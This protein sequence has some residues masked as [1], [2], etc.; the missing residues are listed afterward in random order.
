[1][2]DADAP[3]FKDIS[4][5]I[6]SEP[7]SI[8]KLRKKIVLLDF[9][10][11]SCVNCIRT[12]PTLKELHK[13]YS[14]KDLVIIG[15]HTPEFEFEKNF[16][17]VKKIVEKYGLEYPIA[18]DLQNTTWK[19]YGNSYWPKVV[20]VGARGK[21]KMEH[22]GESG[23]DKIEEKVIEL[24]AENGA[25][26]DKEV[27]IEREKFDRQKMFE[28]AKKITPEIYFG[29]ERSRGFGNSQVCVSGSCIRFIDRGDHQQNLVYLN[30][31]W[32]QEKEFI[33]HPTSEEAH[34]SLKYTAKNVNA[35]LSQFF[36][37]QY[38]VYVLLDG[39]YLDRSV[40]GRDIKLDK[41]GKSFVL[42][43]SSDMYELVETETMQTHEIK[44]VSDSNEFAIYT[45]TFG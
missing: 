42:V 1:M 38:K 18:L 37:K 40:A 39:K 15:V 33:R 4:G 35:V 6:N 25:K 8:F 27:F 23:Y 36:G 44:L 12:L 19:L 14:D 32:E 13:K 9:W 34:V 3:E 16:E 7:L 31:D 20:L 2:F 10:T 45:F 28:I 21:I 30:G 29:S 41:D 22:V 5:W 43:D 17:N 24:L 26:F 11:Y